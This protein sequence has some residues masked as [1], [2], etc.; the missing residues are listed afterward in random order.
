MYHPSSA[1]GAHVALFSGFTC[2]ST[3]M[4]GGAMGSLLKLY[5]PNNCDHAECFGLMRDPRNKFIVI[6]ACGISRSHK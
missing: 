2:T 1:C 6:N 4:P 3:R 5:G